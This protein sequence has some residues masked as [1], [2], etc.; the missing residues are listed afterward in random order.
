MTEE[1]LLNL[2]RSIPEDL[3]GLKKAKDLINFSKNVRFDGESFQI[4]G[5]KAC[6][7]LRRLGQKTKWSNANPYER[8]PLMIKR[9]R[10]GAETLSNARRSCP[11]WG[12]KHGIRV[13]SEIAKFSHNIANLRKVIRKN[14]KKLDPCSERI[15]KFLFIKKWIPIISE[16]PVGKQGLATAVDLIVVDKNTGELIA[17]ELKTGYENENYGPVPGDLPLSFGSLRDCPRHRHELQLAS[18][19]SLMPIFPDK[20]YVIRPASKARGIEWKE[21]KWWKD[22]FQ[23]SLLLKF[24]FGF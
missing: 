23:R 7:L 21:I 11:N 10:R 9:R 20:S 16:L 1:K 2:A 4:N 13:H 18:T 15:I 19:C 3:S 12:N 8:N 6:G 14:S 22:P 5:K 17:I 24:L